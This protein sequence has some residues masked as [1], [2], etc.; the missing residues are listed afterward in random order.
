MPIQLTGGVLPFRLFTSPATLMASCEGAR[1]LASLLDMPD[2]RIAILCTSPERLNAQSMIVYPLSAVNARQIKSA[3]DSIVASTDQPDHEA[4]WATIECAK[5]LFTSPTSAQSRNSLGTFGQLFVCTGNPSGLP[6]LLDPGL[7]I[8]VICPGTVPWKG[9]RDVMCNGWKMRSLCRSGPE[10]VANKNGPDTTALSTLF[11]TAIARA[12]GGKVSG[13]LTDLVLEVSAG[14]NCSVEGV[15]GKKTYSSLRPGEIITVL[16]KVKV[17][18]WEK[19]GSSSSDGQDPNSSPNSYELLDQL[20]RMLGT[21]STTV[22]TARLKY[23]HSLFPSGTRC[24]ISAHSRVKHQVIE[25]RGDEDQSKALEHTIWVQKRLIFHLATH[26]SPKNAL[27]TLMDQFGVDGRHSVCPNYFKLVV[28]EL[29]YQA[30]VLGRLEAFDVAS[31]TAN[32]QETEWEHFGEGLFEFEDFKPIEWM[33]AE[34]QELSDKD[35]PGSVK[36]EAWNS[37][38]PLGLG[39]VSSY[40]TRGEGAWLANMTHR[41]VTSSGGRRAG[42]ARIPYTADHHQDDGSDGSTIIGLQSKYTLDAPVA[43]HDSSSKSRALTK[44][45][46]SKENRPFARDT[47][48]PT[49]RAGRRIKTIGSRTTTPKSTR[50]PRSW[51]SDDEGGLHQVSPLTAR[52]NRSTP[53]TP[54]TPSTPTTPTTRTAPPT[55]GPSSLSERAAGDA[56]TVWDAMGTLKVGGDGGARYPPMPTPAARPAPRPAQ[57]QQ[58][59]GVLRPPRAAPPPTYPQVI[60]A[61]D[62]EERVRLMRGYGL[63]NGKQQRDVGQGTGQGHGVQNENEHQS[64][65]RGEGS[66]QGQGTGAGTGPSAPGR[67]GGAGR[68]KRTGTFRGFGRMG[69]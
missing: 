33:P 18:A 28:D 4:T 1:Y 25:N 22:L 34:T 13:R 63:Q 31:I 6:A 51:C 3:V 26:H 39:A 27:V 36:A 5:E 59:Y 47:S 17:G 32:D 60:V 7:H 50:G 55:P 57:Q 52:G 43:G 61:K 19:Y 20:D 48:H 65:Q 10:F 46:S 15:M 9:Q 38:A 56:H 16:V 54:R 35:S 30:R 21:T 69:V 45:V 42:K 53:Q 66:G 49:L 24:S 44:P 64:Q 23:K 37:R 12:R 29:K 68:G 14:H 62:E 67:G 8:H 40:D 58:P 2:D 41:N 11:Q